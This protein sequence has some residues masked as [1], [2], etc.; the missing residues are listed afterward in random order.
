MERAAFRIMSRGR[1]TVRILADAI[2][3]QRRRGPLEPNSP[4]LLAAYV[5]ERCGLGRLGVDK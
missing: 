1:L 2:R 5:W 3:R 4:A